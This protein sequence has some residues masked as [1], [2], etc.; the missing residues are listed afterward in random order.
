MK[1][2]VKLIFIALLITSFFSCNSSKTD[3]PNYIYCDLKNFSLRIELSSDTAVYGE[4]VWAKLF[5]KNNS[6]EKDSIAYFN[7]WEILESPMILNSNVKDTNW[8]CKNPDR[9]GDMIVD[10]FKVPYTV[11]KPNEEK[12]E[13]IY[14]S[15]SVYS[16]SEDTTYKTYSHYL[17]PADY[18]VSAHFYSRCFNFQEK[19]SDNTLN[20]KIV[21]IDLKAFN[22]LLA[23]VDDRSKFSLTISKDSVIKYY[24]SKIEEYKNSPYENEFFLRKLYYAHITAY[25]GE[26][27]STGSL[28]KLTEEI[29]YH[30]SEN[31]NASQVHAFLDY[32]KIL[33][34]GRQQDTL[35]TNRYLKD[36]QLKYPSKRIALWAKEY[37]ERDY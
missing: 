8:D 10:Y 9:A 19:K 23:D 1:K 21:N 28:K 31:P 12:Y 22:E 33:N 4:T 20:L 15:R 37:L 26:N 11:F 7:K 30:V 25:W 13:Y 36:L 34:Y 17:I 32:F 35:G 27:D 2:P 16:C 29:K 5:V 14:F 3:D 6:D 24:D 18:K